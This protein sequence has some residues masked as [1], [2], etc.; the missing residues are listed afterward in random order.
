MDIHYDDIG[1]V[2]AITADPRRVNPCGGTY[3][4]YTYEKMTRLIAAYPDCTR[5]TFMK[6]VMRVYLTGTGLPVLIVPNAA[7]KRGYLFLADD[8]HARRYPGIKAPY[9]HDLC[10]SN[11]WDDAAEIVLARFWAAQGNVDDALSKLGIQSCHCCR[12]G[13]GLTDPISRARGIG[14]KCITMIG[15]RRAYYDALVAGLI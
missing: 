13:A 14:P 7:N 4:D 9:D 11:A 10:A 5:V 2:L 8:R 3:P 6:Q 15:V 1:T 12:C